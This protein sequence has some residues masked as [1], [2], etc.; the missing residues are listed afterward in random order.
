MDNEDVCNWLK[1]DKRWA[2]LR[3]EDN[4]VIAVTTTY[5]QAERVSYLSRDYYVHQI[6]KYK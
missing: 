2:V 3:Q 1:E 4:G 6:D 5:E